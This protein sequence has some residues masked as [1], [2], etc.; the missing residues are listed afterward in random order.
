LF[1]WAGD[2]AT[3][4]QS[5]FRI[6]DLSVLND[7]IG[8][9]NRMMLGSENIDQVLLELGHALARRQSR[10]EILLV[11]GSAMLLR[12]YGSRTTVDIDVMGLRVGSHFVRAVP[13]PP[14]LVAAAAE[15]GAV[16]GFPATWLNPGPTDLLDDGLPSGYEQRLE[17][18]AFDALT[19]DVLGRADLVALKLLAASD[20]TRGQRD[21]T[22]LRVLAPERSELI[23]AARWALDVR[24]RRFRSDIVYLVERLG[25]RDA[26][27]EL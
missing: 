9:Y 2:R 5:P 15:I 1:D 6:D 17:T 25:L 19:V 20:P 16:F 8:W 26:E 22:D 10:H 7:R 27:A 23:N 14:D 4:R 24:Y 11:G 3:Y 12:G 13:L 21:M 18:R